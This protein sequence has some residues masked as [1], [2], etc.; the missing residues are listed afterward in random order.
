MQPPDG[1]VLVCGL[2]RV[3]SRVLEFLHRAGVPVAVLDSAP[4]PAVPEGVT[5]YS[6]D[7]RDPKSLL[8]AGADRA[9]GFVVCTSDDLTNLAC[10]FAVR[11][12]N[13]E[14]RIVVRMFNESL[15]DRLGSAMSNTTALS[16]SALTAPLLVVTALTGDSL[17]S[18]PAGDAGAMRVAELL[19]TLPQA[20]RRL[21]DVAG[22][23]R[24]LVVAVKP[25]GKPPRLFA[26]IQGDEKLQFGDRLTLCGPAADV[27]RLL[28]PSEDPLSSVYWAGR[29]RRAVRGFLRAFS[30][31]DLAV[32]LILATLG[33]TLILSTLIFHF[34]LGTTWAEG[35]YRTVSVVGTVTDL[36]GDAL[37]GW[38]KVFVSLLRLAGAAMVAAFTAILTQY[39][40]RAKLAGALE[41]RKI[42]DGG[43][44]VVCGLGNVGYRCVEELKRLGIPAVVIDR[45]PQAS[46]APTVRRMGVAVI[47]GD[48]ATP[49]VLS[50]ARAATARA[51]IAATASELANLEI[52][53]LVR[54]QNP[55]ARVVVRLTE[56]D[57]AEA[58]RT[59]TGLTLAA[60]TS[61]IAAPAFAAALSG[62]RVRLLIPTA[63]RTLAAVELIVRDGDGCLNGVPLA[64][65]MLDYEFLPVALAGREPF[66][67]AGIPGMA[68]LKSG[69]RLTLLV[70]LDKLARL[71]AREPAPPVWRVVIERVAPVAAADLAALARTARNCTQEEADALVAAT[72]FTLAEGLTR[73]AAAELLARAARERCEGRVEQ[74]RE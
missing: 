12:L 3:G 61:T 7:C 10:A 52:A 33:T 29:L 54:E 28:A 15:V 48:A 51:V 42:P 45:D 11:R 71:L 14:G 36:H 25:F 62:D 8:A 31:V 26:D 27:E 1:P 24:L 44:V 57:F 16:V 58:V 13:R 55:A 74:D 22:E 30:A 56:P 32:K 50:Q 2:G 18:F 65:A 34:A 49:A 20:G 37:P 63:G 72:P 73:G 70:E 47:Q 46:F 43:H 35:L 23:A 17:G 64:A 19:I 38:A 9:R 60:S 66:A 6:G 67:G 39:L 53:L 5:A 69:D 41:A 21:A 40:V 4:R 68:R 59:A